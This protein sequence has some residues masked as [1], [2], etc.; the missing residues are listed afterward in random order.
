MKKFFKI[1]AYIITALV[2]CFTGLLAYLT[3]TDYRPGDTLAL[4]INTATSATLS[5]GDELKVLTMN[6]G[7][8]GLGSESDFFLDGGQQVQPPSKEI[9]Q[10]NLDGIKKI[11]ETTQ[12]NIYLLQEVDRGSTRSYSFDEALHYAQEGYTWSYAINYSCGFVPY[13]IPPIGKVESGIMTMSSLTTSSADR[14]KLPSP[15]KWPVS[16]ANLKRCLLVSRIPVGD[17]E[18]VVVNLHLEAYDDG[19]GKIAQFE[20]LRQIC[21]DEY[22]LGNYVIAGGDFNC[23][24]PGADRDLYPLTSTDNYVPGTVDMSGF[25]ED[26]KLVFD[27]STPT[28]RLL[29]SPYDESRADTQYY[30]I[31]GFII[32]PN[33]ELV[34]VNT[35]NENFE[36]TDHNPVSMTVRLVG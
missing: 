12:A 3:I 8:A 21:Q 36:F 24:F 20:I 13:P 26:W 28:C 2:L 6:T 31:D 15:F 7:Y 9:V 35:I 34:S 25:S 22:A 27:E 5:P 16:T 23:S 17:K 10:K 33:V 18:L 19:S 30:V 11:I 1:A 32:S 4:D 29:D 14:V